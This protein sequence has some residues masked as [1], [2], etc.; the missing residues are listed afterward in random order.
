[1]TYYL[2]N[3]KLIA[4]GEQQLSAAKPR[5][6]TWYQYSVC[7]A[8][9]VSIIIALIG[10]EYLAACLLIGL[11]AFILRCTSWNRHLNQIVKAKRW[12]ADTISLED[13]QILLRTEE[14]TKVRTI[15]YNE[16]FRIEQR[17][18]LERIHPLP[19]KYGTIRESFSFICLYLDV[20]RIPENACAEDY[21]EDPGLIL[22]PFYPSAWNILSEKLPELTKEANP[23]AAN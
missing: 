20:R 23:P 14:N 21:R 17:V 6:H 12:Y 4:A 16:I 7:A 22:F 3:P 10:R 18:L 2:H 15:Q 11:T 9:S 13:D 1:M 5:Y 19:I 8:F